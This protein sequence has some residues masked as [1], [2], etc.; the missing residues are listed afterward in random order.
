M[1]TNLSGMTALVTGASGGIGRAAA[2]AFADEGCNLVL[3]A[4]ARVDALEGYVADRP[5][6]D[7]AMCGAADAREP[8]AIASLIE[9]GVER[10][11]RIDVCVAN[12]G[13]WPPDDLLLHEMPV[14]RIRDVLE[15]NLLGVVWTARAFMTALARVGPRGDG[16]GASI[17]LVGSTAGRFG[18]PGHVEYAVSKSGLVGL[19]RSVKNEIT[20]I[21]PYGRI[22]MVEPGWTAT[23]MAEPALGQ[24]ATIGKVLST[25]PLR[26]LGRAEDIARAIVFFSS[27]GLSRHTTGEI[28][29]VAGGME[30]R[31]LWRDGDIDADAVRARLDED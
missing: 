16:R 26:Q 12:A 19:V 24:D 22:N 7:R 3:A 4:G 25:M 6:R 14:E 1:H 29:T 8:E 23:P 13:V 9:R 20:R 31:L 27:P 21:D 17:C 18:E 28:L 11:G 15:V 2:E 30:G 10:F 5:W